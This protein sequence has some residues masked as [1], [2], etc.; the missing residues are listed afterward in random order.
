LHDE[1]QV[2]NNRRCGHAEKHDREFSSVTA[3][4]DQ[5]LADSPPFLGVAIPQRIGVHRTSSEGGESAMTLR[6]WFTML[7]A[8]ARREDGQTMA[9]YAVILTVIAAVVITALGFLVLAITGRL[10]SVTDVI[11]G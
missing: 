10:D 7:N 5:R 3:P 1:A 4:V 6:N 8:F 11:N 9:E 2:T